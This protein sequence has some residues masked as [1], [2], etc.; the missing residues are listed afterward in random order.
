MDIGWIKCSIGNFKAVY[1]ISTDCLIICIVLTPLTLSIAG[2]TWFVL[3]PWYQW[4]RWIYPCQL[5]FQHPTT[6]PTEHSSAK[7]SCMGNW[8]NLWVNYQEM[9]L[10][11]NIVQNAK[12]KLSIAV[13]KILTRFLPLQIV[14]NITNTIGPI[15]ISNI[16]IYVCFCWQ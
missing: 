14:G 7:S 9:Q 5:H 15:G 11:V 16:R 13:S 12:K 6:W 2:H 1:I 8:H 10:S 4:W 3:Y